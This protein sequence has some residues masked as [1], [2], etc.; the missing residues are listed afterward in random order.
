MIKARI[1]LV[2]DEE[3]VRRSLAVNLKREGFELSSAA[4]AE[5]ALAI[6]KEEPYD[7][8]LTDYLMEG[9]TGIE[10]LK[11]AKELNPQMKVIVFSGYEDKDSSDEII[12]LG[13]NGFIC[14]PVDFEELLERIAAV[15][16]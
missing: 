8:L 16:E 5:E 13:A 3:L 15:L 11:L 9:M 14:K 12:R 4:S 1:L 7:L 2:D 6:L 10:L